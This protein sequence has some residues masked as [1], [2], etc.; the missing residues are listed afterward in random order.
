MADFTNNPYFTAQENW[1]DPLKISQTLLDTLTNLRKFLNTPIHINVGTQGTHIQNSQHYLG[2]AVDCMIEN[3]PLSPLDLI[4]A[5]TRFPFGGVGY[6]PLWKAPLMSAG[7]F[8]LDVRPM[9]SGYSARWIGV[10]DGKGG[11]TYMELSAENLKKYGV[12]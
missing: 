4:L 1:G 10:E 12:I 5:V 8:H 7:G 11:N 3:G 6:Y 2:L 9:V